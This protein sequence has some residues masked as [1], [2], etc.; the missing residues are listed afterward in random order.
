[1]HGKPVTDVTRQVLDQPELSQAWVLIH[2]DDLDA[3]G[4]DQEILDCIFKTLDE[5]WSIKKTEPDF[6]LGINR[7]VS[8][9]MKCNVTSCEH[10]MEAYTTGVA[11]TF[12]SDLP[13]KTL[14]TIFRA[15][16]T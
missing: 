8:M 10:S 13:K 2:T 7:K 16:C 14:A 1:M 6:M 12:R 15:S 11:E 4:T 5:R 9:D 3:N